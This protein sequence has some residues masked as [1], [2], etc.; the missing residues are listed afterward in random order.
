VRNLGLSANQALH[1]PAGGD[2]QIK[3][4]QV[5]DKPAP[6][7]FTHKGKASD[8]ANSA[9]AMEVSASELCILP[10]PSQQEQLLRENDADELVGEQTWPTDKVTRIDC[11]SLSVNPQKEV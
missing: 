5:L 10:D 4:M 7:G 9:S 6:L 3:Q 8:N 11:P 1:I 2:F